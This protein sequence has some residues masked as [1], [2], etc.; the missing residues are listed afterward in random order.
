MRTG[1]GSADSP[2]GAGTEQDMTAMLIF[3]LISLLIGAALGFLVAFLIFR[4]NK[5]AQP[6]T[7]VAQQQGFGQPPQG[8][9]PP[10]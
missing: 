6:Q 5:P 8:P 1:A 7:F 2:S 3:V 9:H 4:N 10:R